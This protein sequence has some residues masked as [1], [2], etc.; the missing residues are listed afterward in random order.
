MK[1]ITLKLPDKLD[2]YHETLQ[3]FFEGMLWKLDNNAS[4]GEA[5]AEDQLILLARLQVELGELI[6]QMA[7]DDTD[8]NV[9][10]ET[11]DVANF[12]FLISHSLT[13]RGAEYVPK[14]WH[15]TEGKKGR[16]RWWERK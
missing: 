15:R 4:K 2:Y 9:L 7:E 3:R 14:S 13:V 12:A 10:Y 1:E 6:E 11:Y 16:A 8:P 5:R